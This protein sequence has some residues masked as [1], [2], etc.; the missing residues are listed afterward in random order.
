MRLNIIKI[1]SLLLA[2]IL[3]G[4]CNDEF[5]ELD[6]PEAY[7]EN[8]YFKT[9][10][11]INSAVI[12]T[13]ATLLHRGMHA[14][15]W[16]FIFDL[17]GS[18]AMKNT[19]LLGDDAEFYNFSFQNTNPR[20]QELWDT[21]YRMRTR[22]VIV[23]DKVDEWQPENIEEARLQ[24]IYKGEGYFMKS[25][26]YFNLVRMFGAIP[27]A[28]T[29]NDVKDT[30][31]L[32]RP[33][34]EESVVYDS[35]IADLQRAVERLPESW[36]DANKGRATKYSAH[37]LLGKVYLTIGEYAMA[38]NQFMEIVNSGRFNLWDGTE[39]YENQFTN[40]NWDSPETIFDVRHNWYGWSAGNAYH[41]FGGN[42]TW[43]GRAANSGRAMEYGFNDWWNVF[44]SSAAV[45]SFDYTVEGASYMDP[46]SSLVFYGNPS[47]GGDGNWAGGTYDYR[48]KGN[49][50]KKYNRYETIVKEGNPTSD[51]NTQLIRYADVLL[52]IAETYIFQDQYAEA[53]PYINEVRRR[54]GA[55][56]YTTV[57]ASFD[58]A[59][60][61]LR[62]ERRLE[63]VGEQHRWF[64]LKRWHL[65]D[66]SSAAGFD[67]V[68]VIN[69]DRALDTKNN[70]G[71]MAE[72]YIYLPIPINELQ[73]NPQLDNNLNYPNWN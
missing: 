39:G 23:I 60:E 41:M 47:E 26:A 6:N 25:F 31:N 17:M 15:D 44:V 8:T 55:L 63:L 22:A 43:G 1:F 32:A 30:D 5:L 10:D 27:Y 70:P 4:A 19:F 59:F 48:A 57:P 24:P 62:R 45:E 21:N 33:R 40:A 54:V 28:D 34:T 11:Q 12:G 7:D 72:K 64:D 52:M 16:Y 58:E 2:F 29:W 18:D 3:L 20:L 71:D 56:E 65:A 51:I 35:I 49:S 68:A 9:Q 66:K 61:I 73:N 37:A 38:R 42:E 13:Y 53:L 69:A 14:R 67:M 46:R 36:D 50:W